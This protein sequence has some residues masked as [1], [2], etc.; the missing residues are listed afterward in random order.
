MAPRETA[1]G[2]KTGKCERNTLEE[3]LQRCGVWEVAEGSYRCTEQLS[4]AQE[5]KCFSMYQC[6]QRSD[7]EFGDN[8]SPLGCAM[9]KNEKDSHFFVDG[10]IAAA[11]HKA[12][13]LH[14]CEPVLLPMFSLISLWLLIS[15]HQ[16]FVFCPG[17]EITIAAAVNPFIGLSTLSQSMALLHS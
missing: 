16:E 6:F 9:S 14:S 15:E 8:L 1:E 10:S 2:Q 4:S 11:P 3:G 12:E 13:V 7:R 5:N 17:S